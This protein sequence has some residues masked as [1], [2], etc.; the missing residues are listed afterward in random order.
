MFSFTVHP[1]SLEIWRDCIEIALDEV[2]NRNSWRPSKA[3]KEQKGN[4]WPRTSVVNGGCFPRNNQGNHHWFMS[5]F[6]FLRSPTHYNHLRHLECWGRGCNKTPITDWLKR[7]NVPRKLLR[8]SSTFRRWTKYICGQ[9]FRANRIGNEY[10]HCIMTHRNYMVT[11]K[12]IADLECHIMQSGW[13][14]DNYGNISSP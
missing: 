3:Q 13:F 8:V 2:W 4:C 12:A 14:P 6:K 7:K 5:R 1:S 11:L 9:S 10:Q